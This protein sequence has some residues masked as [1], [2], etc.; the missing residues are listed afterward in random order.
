AKKAY[1]LID[2]HH[3]ATDGLSMNIILQEFAAL[4]DGHSLPPVPRQCRHAQ[5]ELERQLRQGT[6]DDQKAYWKNVFP[7]GEAP[8]LDLPLDYPRPAVADFAGSEYPFSLSPEQTRALD[9]FAA[10]SGVSLYMVLLGA[11]ATL[12][13]R[14]THTEDLVIGL[15]VGGRSSAEN[16]SVVGMFVNSLPLRLSPSSDLSFAALL[17]QVKER[18]LDAYDHQDY[19]YGEL[20]RDLGWTISP[21]RN[22]GFDVMFAYENADER[23]LHLN[24]LRI[25]TI[26]QYEGSGMFD[27]NAD[28]IRENDVLSIRFHYAS[29]LFNPETIER[30][31]KYYRNLL[32]DILSDPTTPLRELG[33]V[34]DSESGLLNRWSHSTTIAT[35]RHQTLLGIWKQSLQSH[36]D[37]IAL[38]SGD[39]QLTYRELDE[40]AN[41]LAKAILETTAIQPDDRIG[42]CTD[43]NEHWV[44]G[45]IAIL[46]CS[47]AWVPLDPALPEE[48]IRFMLEDCDAKA[49]LVDESGRRADGIPVIL[50]PDKN[51]PT[52][53]APG[54]DPLPNHLAYV[55]YTSGSTGKP[56]GVMIEHR[57][58]ASSVQ[59]RHAYYG[60]SSSDVTL[61]MPSMAFD[62]SVADLFPTL[63]AGACMI[64]ATSEQKRQLHEVE[65]LIVRHNATNLLVTPGLYQLML[66]EI[67]S[68]LSRLRFVTLA[69]ESIPLPLVSNHFE[70]IPPVRLINEYG[71]TENSVIATAGDLLPEYRKVSIGRP[72]DGV[73]V[74]ILAPDGRKCPQ[75]VV[76]EIVLGGA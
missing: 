62:A 74:N 33:M 15:P 2:A 53:H 5:D 13:H 58:I 27:F 56:K 67:P 39:I 57:S 37:A 60:F 70:A 50:I 31:A 36:A 9:A 54:I 47:A 71:P 42:L 41:G 22:P 20:I 26:D 76:G 7:S 6:L 38:V 59:W 4:Y 64:L 8:L 35:T 73:T 17:A 55:I 14:L 30:W 45:I 66:T 69:G 23:I 68:V 16:E 25:S 34:D 63:Q 40:K 52:A 10:K 51:R 3:L 12:L 72:I 19:P 48:R 24:E 1:L 61:Q 65:S 44:T 46:K 21:D 18:A 75:G 32:E 29:S 43:T 11:F 28:L 49:L